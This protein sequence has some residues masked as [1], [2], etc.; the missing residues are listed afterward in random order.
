MAADIEVAEC[1]R[2]IVLLGTAQRATAPDETL[3][4]GDRVGCQPATKREPVVFDV[5]G[6]RPRRI[7]NRPPG[8]TRSQSERIP[9]AASLERKPIQLLQQVV[10]LDADETG[11][12]AGQD[13]LLD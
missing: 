3:E 13:G 5:V 7:G 8:N 12:I 1:A 10:P 9:R 11:L 4:R 2:T 6:R